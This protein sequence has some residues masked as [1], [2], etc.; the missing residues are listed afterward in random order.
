[1]VDIVKLL[2]R[3]PRKEIAKYLS[4]AEVL[5]LP[6]P[7]GEDAPLK[8]YEYLKSGKPIVATDIAA[9]RAVLSDKTAIL[10]EPKAIAK[11]ITRALQDADHTKKIVQAAAV[12]S[13]SAENKPLK[14]C[15]EE[16]YRFIAGCKIRLI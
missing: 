2:P 1:M 7:E 16:A 10:I 4:P 3:C 15:L 8:I 14:T 11:G 12:A 5:V 9:H 13:G 6:P